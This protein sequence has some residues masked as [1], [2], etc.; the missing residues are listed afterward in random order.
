M[1]RNLSANVSSLELEIIPAILVKSRADLLK[2][3][4]LV[5][6][7][8]KTVQID[9]MDND[10]VPNKTIGIEELQ[11]LPDGVQYEFHW[12]VQN[13]ERWIKEINEGRNDLHLIHIEA[14]MDFDNVK[15]AVKK[16]GGTL[17]VAINPPTPIEKIYPYEKEKAVSQIL[18]MSVNPG[19]SGQKYISGVEEK[20]RT[21]HQ[22]NPDL[23]IEVDGGISLETIG[24]AASA[25]ANKLCAASAIYAAESVEAAIDQLEVLARGGYGKDS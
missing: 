23:D 12:M 3:I 4:E 1:G 19:F 16:V 11:S 2:Q 13:P 8:V 24:Q 22:R 10:F 15:K 14:K 7:Y 5:K 21:L 6:P 17:G 18:I 9:V 20:I 25:G